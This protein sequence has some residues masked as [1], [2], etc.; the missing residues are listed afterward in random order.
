MLF[1]QLNSFI[2]SD[3]EGTGSTIR[4]TTLRD[5]DAAAAKVSHPARKGKIKVVAVS[6]NLFLAKERFVFRGS[7]CKNQ[8]LKIINR[9]NHVNYQDGGIRFAKTSG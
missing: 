5:R 7:Q 4:P 3:G 2:K 9:R 6:L 8:S 1:L